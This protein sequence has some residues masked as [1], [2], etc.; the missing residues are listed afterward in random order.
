MVKMGFEKNRRLAVNYRNKRCTEI[1]G[2]KTCNF[3]SQ[4]EYRVAKY[5]EVLKVAKQIKDWHYERTKFKFPDDSYLVDFD[6]EELDGSV[7][8]IEAKGYITAKTRRN[9][10]LLGKYEPDVILDMVFANKRDMAKLRTGAKYCRRVV[11]IGDL[12]RGII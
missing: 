2:G 4:L 7:Y 5:L 9:L 11:W 1:V 3:R 10:R 12:T 8:H 6:V